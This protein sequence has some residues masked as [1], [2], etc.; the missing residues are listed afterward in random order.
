M[1]FMGI[2]MTLEEFD[3]LL[4]E[5]A[6]G[7]ELKVEN[8][9]VVAT[10]HIPTQEEINKQRVYELKGLLSS[11]DYI[12]NKLAEAIADALVSGDNSTVYE[13]KTAYAKQLQDRKTWR[14][15]IDTLEK[16]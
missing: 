15:E 5:Q 6:S 3:H 7:K 13:L 9:E 12:A 11:T 14:E 1:N 4:C 10:E 16:K 8:G 2:E